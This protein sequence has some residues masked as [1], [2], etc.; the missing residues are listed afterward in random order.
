VRTPLLVFG[1]VVAAGFS[2]AAVNG[3]HAQTRGAALSG[4][5]SSAEEGPMEGVLVSAKR[6]GSNITV[7]VVSNAQGRY[8]LPAAKL[9]A[10]TYALSIRAVGYDLDGKNS[11]DVGAQGGASADIRLKKT[12]D[13]AGQLSNAEWLASMPGTDAQKKSLLDCVSCHEIAKIVNTRYTAD[14]FMTVIPRMAT[15]A[16]GT[17]PLQP[18]RRLNTPR[19]RDPQQLR[20]MA[21]YLASVNLS[22]G[23]PWKY[24]LKTLPR[25]KGASDDVVITEY[26]LPRRVTEP[27]DVVVDAQGM[28]WYSD[29][30][31]QV[32]GEVN[33]RTGEV[34]EFQLPVL[35]AGQ[36]NGELDLELDKSGMMWLGMMMQG[37]VAEFDPKAKAFKTFPL[38]EK[39]NDNA[40]QIAMVTPPN[41]GVMWTNDVDKDSAHRLNLTTGQWDTFGPIT[42][43]T[44]RLSIYGLYADSH[45]NA[46]A[47]DFSPNDGSYLGKVDGTT[48]AMS[49]IPTP[50]KNVRLRRGRFDAQDR[51]WFAEYAGN[52]IGM[53]DANTGKMTEWPL[54]TPWTA[55][56]DVVADKR[57][58]IWTGSM[59]TDRVSRLDPK[60]GKVVEYM[61][62][63]TTNIR[64]VFV[65]NTTTPVTFWVGSNH[66][67]SIVKVEPQD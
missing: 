12:T 57:G 51:L 45:N 52:A 1:A 59:W 4:I 17:T 8:A 35:K 48:G 40:A 25:L 38:P 20:A 66:G 22:T 54:P 34:T 65:E 6:A 26:D 41:N 18:Q 32:L 43:G 46:Y 14:D 58:E 56:Y 5:V 13:L 2:V 7:T 31:T 33:P 28:A 11:V 62:P 60:S 49:L 53:Y 42:D 50:T 10:G 3:I 44:H 55:P 24:P 19:A 29:F 47:M 67:A 37:G 27:H 63:R 61:L 36:A 9:G 15:Y 21:E 30:G 16:P 64:R 39:W 23:S